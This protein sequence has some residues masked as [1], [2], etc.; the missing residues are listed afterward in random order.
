MAGLAV[1]L[2][3]VKDGGAAGRP[4]DLWTFRRGAVLGVIFWPGLRTT[5]E[6]VDMLTGV[7]VTRHIISY[8]P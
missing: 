8:H 1:W 2:S 4:L 6:K 3:G 5:E 7:D